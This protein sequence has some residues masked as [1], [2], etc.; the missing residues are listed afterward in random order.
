MT[1]PIVET[2]DPS[3]QPEL[4]DDDM[5]LFAEWVTDFVA[6]ELWMHG[7]TGRILSDSRGQFEVAAEVTVTGRRLTVEWRPGVTDRGQAWLNA[8]A[9]LAERAYF[10]GPGDE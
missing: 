1:T 8:Q 4:V 5:N 7:T 6:F 3:G 2:T 9:A 10:E